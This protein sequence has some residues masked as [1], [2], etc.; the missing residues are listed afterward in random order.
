M[1]RT[2]FGSSRSDGQRRLVGVQVGVDA[3]GFPPGDSAVGGAQDHVPE[4]VL[5]RTAVHEVGR[6]HRIGGRMFFL[7]VLAWHDGRVEQEGP[8]RL[9]DDGPISIL[10][11]LDVGRPRPELGEIG[12]RGGPGL[13]AIVRVGDKQVLAV[14]AQLLLVRRMLPAGLVDQEDPSFSVHAHS[15]HHLVGP[16]EFRRRGGPGLA[17]VG[18]RVQDGRIGLERQVDGP[19]RM[20]RHGHHRPFGGARGDDGH[21][22]VDFDR[23]PVIHPFFLCL[24]GCFLAGRRDQQEQRQPDR[25]LFHDFSFSQ[26]GH[27]GSGDGRSAN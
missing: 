4:I 21:Q 16:A 19:V 25:N 12:F 20:P 3:G 1:T 8:V 24:L 10:V 5:R 18:A 7:V 22:P 11:E 2:W 17:I 15:L 9:L 6:T 26:S 23:H 14:E 13:A 27:G